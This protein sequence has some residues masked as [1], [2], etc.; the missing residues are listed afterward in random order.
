VKVKWPLGRALDVTW[1]D[2]AGQ[3]WGWAPPA[4][5]AG[6]KLGLCRSIGYVLQEDRD[7]VVLMQSQSANGTVDQSLTIAKRLIVS[8]RR[9]R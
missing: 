3:P 6:A 4:E 5:Y 1:K 9:V 7:C 8:R 2:H